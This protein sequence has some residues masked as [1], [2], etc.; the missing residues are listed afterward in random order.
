MSLF[1]SPFLYTIGKALDPTGIS[2]YGDAKEAI[3]QYDT[4]PSVGN[5]YNAV[6][7]TVGVL[8]IVS[9]AGKAIKFLQGVVTGQGIFNDYN[10]AKE[11]QQKYGEELVVDYWDNTVKPRREAEKHAEQIKAKMSYEDVNHVPSFKLAPKDSKLGQIIHDYNDNHRVVKKY[12]KA[13][14]GNLFDGTSQPSQKR[15]Y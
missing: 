4:N 3:T 12:K 14:G 11:Q 7:E 5:A 13:F 1:F 8:P 2:G 6:M 10:H 15:C 9:K